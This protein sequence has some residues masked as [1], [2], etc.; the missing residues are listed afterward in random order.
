MTR[1]NLVYSSTINIEK[2]YYE[3]V[4][5]NTCSFVVRFKCFAKS[6]QADDY[7]KAVVA[8]I[9]KENISGNNVD[10]LY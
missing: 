8:H 5:F 4:D 1:G 7:N 10:I 2:G 9:I 3:K 6:V